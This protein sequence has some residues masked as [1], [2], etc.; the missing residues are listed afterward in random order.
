MR[1][2]L[3]RRARDS[4]LRSAG[5]LLLRVR[6][7]PPA[8]WP[9]GG[10]ESLRS[11]CYGLAIYNKTKAIYI[12]EA[13]TQSIDT[14]RELTGSIPY[15]PTIFITLALPVQHQLGKHVSENSAKSKVETKGKP[16]CLTI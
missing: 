2:H 9:D 15:R 12:E 8:P 7:L 5:T 4:V 14:L 1:K 11:P 10:P 13:A 16:V 6:A 3:L